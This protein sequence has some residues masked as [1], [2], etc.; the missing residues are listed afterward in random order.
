MPFFSSKSKKQLKQKQAKEAAEAQED[1]SRAPS[2]LADD[3]VTGVVEQ[4]AAEDMGNEDPDSPASSTGEDSQRGYGSGSINSSGRGYGSGSIATGEQHRKRCSYCV[5]KFG[6]S[7][8]VW[9]CCDLLS[10]RLNLRPKSGFF[11]V[12]SVT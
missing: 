1:A 3:F 11:L 8:C 9:V 6:L 2:G 7:A 4:Q 10:R 5:E 12:S